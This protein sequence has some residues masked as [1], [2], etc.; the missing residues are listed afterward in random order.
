MCCWLIWLS[1]TYP[2]HPWL[3]SGVGPLSHFYTPHFV[4][5]STTN[6]TVKYA[7]LLMY[8]PFCVIA[9]SFDFVSKEGRV[10]VWIC[11]FRLA[12]MAMCSTWN[13]CCSTELTWAPR[14]HLETPPC[15]CVL[16]TTRYQWFKKKMCLYAW[17]VESSVDFH[18]YWTGAQYMIY[19]QSQCSEPMQ[20]CHF[21]WDTRGRGSCC[22]WKSVGFLK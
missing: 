3:N 12:A 5:F 21:T 20:E 10:N 1:C 13:T 19:T 4:Y 18:S 11:P 17:S 15:T 6:M 9:P 22:I 2:L 14:M 16:S 8:I 7:V